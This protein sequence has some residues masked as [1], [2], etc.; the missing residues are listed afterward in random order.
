[1]QSQ[2][3]PRRCIVVSSPRHSGTWATRTETQSCRTASYITCNTTTSK[4]IL[5]TGIATVSIGRRSPTGRTT[6]FNTL[7]KLS[8]PM[9]LPVPRW[10]LCA[11][12]Y[13]TSTGMGATGKK[14]TRYPVKNN[15]RLA[16]AFYAQS[17]TPRNTHFTTVPIKP[18]VT[19]GMP[20]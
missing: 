8:T 5:P 20:S 17:K 14:M 3:Q 15:L 11:A 7:A 19:L 16:N 1:M 12:S 4:P 18:S 13:M 9:G 10:Q 2:L 6:P